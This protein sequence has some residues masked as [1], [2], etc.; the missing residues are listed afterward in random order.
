MARRIPRKKILVRARLHQTVLEPF[1]YGV[2][3][4]VT[5]DGHPVV[6]GGFVAGGGAA[7]IVLAEIADS[8]ATEG[9]SHQA[10]EQVAGASSVPVAARVTALCR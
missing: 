10:G 1:E 3:Q 7:E 5:A 8:A 6:A 2:F 9:A 4:I